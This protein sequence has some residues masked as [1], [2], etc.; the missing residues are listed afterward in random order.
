MRAAEAANPLDSHPAPAH[1]PDPILG[2]VDPY[3]RP[4]VSGARAAL[5]QA[6]KVRSAYG[7]ARLERGRSQWVLRSFV[8]E[9]FAPQRRSKM[10]RVLI[11]AAVV[12]A[13]PLV[14][15]ACGGPRLPASPVAAPLTE[16]QA[17]ELAEARLG[18]R[19]EGSMLTTIE[20]TR[21]GYLLGYVTEFDPGMEPPKAAQLVAVEHDGTVREY[22]FRRDQ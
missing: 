7:R 5:S 22:N 10:R 16:L 11:H 19:L 9:A 21:K 15:A 4:A 18:D 13:L 6:Q 20:S 1:H 14:G 12:A 8:P 2:L 17:A 3:H